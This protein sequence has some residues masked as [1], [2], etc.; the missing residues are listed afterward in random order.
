M[1]PLLFCVANVC[2]P[3]TCTIVLAQAVIH[4]GLKE[5]IDD[6]INKEFS[7]I[8]KYLKMEMIDCLKILKDKFTIK[9]AFTM[10]GIF[11]AG[12]IFVFAFAMSLAKA[13]S[14]GER[15]AEHHRQELLNRKSSKPQHPEETEQ[16]QNT[17]D[18]TK[19]SDSR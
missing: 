6:I 15:L 3:G 11:G 4:R 17:A 5:E 1:E 7:S 2:V 19:T 14:R 8:L 10:W 13:S 12:A 18:S 16:Q 9:E